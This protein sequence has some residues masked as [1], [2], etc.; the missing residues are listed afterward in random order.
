MLLSSVT[1]H[2]LLRQGLSLKLELIYLTRLTAKGSSYPCFHGIR[3]KDVRCHVQLQCEYLRSEIR[4][5]CLHNEQF[6]H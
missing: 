1:F 5:L 3:V 2:F 6:A 4:A